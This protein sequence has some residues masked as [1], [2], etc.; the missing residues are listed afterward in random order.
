M[1]EK[2]EQVA[3]QCEVVA[4]LGGVLAE[5][6]RVNAGLVREGRFDNILDIV[7]NWTAHL[8]DEIANVLNDID[9]V[10]EEDGK[11]SPVFEAAHKMFP[12]QPTHVD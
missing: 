12:Q 9:A 7:G 11:Y 2:R 6:G 8:M 4:H 1:D 3:K 5:I 10:G